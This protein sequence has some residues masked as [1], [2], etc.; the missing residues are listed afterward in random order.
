MPRVRVIGSDGEMI[1]VLTRDEA[2]KMAED[3]ALAIL[4]EARANA[5]RYAVESRVQLDAQI[6]RRA[7]QAQDKIAQAEAQAVAEVRA[8]AADAAIAAAEK[9]IVSKL[10]DERSKALVQDALR[11]LG[12]KL[13]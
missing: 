2:L 3:E 12:G 8:L 9:I 7:K 1:G 6:A 13:N 4:T 11:G 5:E 10:N